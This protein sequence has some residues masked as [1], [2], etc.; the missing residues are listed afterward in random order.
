MFNRA[1]GEQYF[2]AGVNEFEVFN[3]FEDFLPHF[4]FAKQSVVKLGS[5]YFVAVGYNAG[6]VAHFPNPGSAKCNTGYVG[7]ADEFKGLIV[8]LIDSFCEGLGFG[9]AETAVVVEANETTVGIV[10][11][12]CRVPVF[13]S[14]FAQN[15]GQTVGIVNDAERI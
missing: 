10:K 4:C 1:D 2:N 11:V 3:T 13:S 8:Q 6:G 15:G 12:V 5:R 14:N 7:F 9:V